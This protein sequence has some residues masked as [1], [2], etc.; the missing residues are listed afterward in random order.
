MTL[1]IADLYEAVADAIPDRVP[2]VCGDERRSY[3]ELDGRAN[4]LAHHLESVGVQP[5]Q[6]VA[7][8]MRNRMEYVEA[9]LACMKIRAVPINVNFRY[10]DAEL[11][12][13][14]TNSES[15]A[16][17]VENEYLGTAGAALPQCPGIG[18]AVV[19]GEHDGMPDG[20]ATVS[21]IDYEDALAAQSD[22]RGF[23]PRSADDR[24]VIYTGGTTG[25]PKGVVWRH[26]DFY[27][28]ALSGGNIGGAPR[29]SVEEVVAGAVANTEPSVY[30]L[31]PPLMH[32][33]AIYSLLT[34]FLMG[35]P[36]VL[37]RTFDPVEVLRLI[38]AERIT[39]VTV[40]GDAIA[41][42][43]ADAIREHGDRYD[44][45]TLKLMGSG[46]ALFSPALK[47]ELR[48]MVPGLVI[49]DAFGAS[50]TGNDGIVEFGD[51][52]TKRIRSN[53]NMILVDEKF[54]P[55]APGADEV[56]Y[57]ARKGH[58][59]VAY[60]NDDAKTAATF[61][62][63]DGVRMAVLGD[64]GRMEAD[65]TILLLGRGSTCINSGGEKVYPEE[66][67][68]ALKTHPAVLDALVA[69]A[70]DVRFGEK[71]AAV[72]QLRPGFDT[73][74]P[75]QIAEHCRVHVAGYKIPRAVVVV[76]AIRRSPSGKA[77]YRWAKEVVAAG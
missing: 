76:E 11:V 8:H 31:I 50:E 59:P 35:A 37:T 63:V 5:G 17:I 13:L 4:R 57:I 20:F 51:D 32:G 62:V 61:P 77:D 6:H 29:H 65:G 24:F 12:Y 10:T 21:V 55:I 14:Y 54:R 30:L 19:V 56:G 60:Y 64:M 49:K 27:Y 66:V 1:N 73:A 26:E 22:A 69:G 23:G 39:G 16:L 58:V 75:D 36:R 71:V 33:A 53:P 40:V 44:L 15:V 70:P 52:G 3:A 43:I 45:S 2:V 68:L 34:A 72:V 25:M 48:G 67:E 18:H 74:D 38:E 28:A 41:R 7:I 42:P 46:G 9:L 47:D